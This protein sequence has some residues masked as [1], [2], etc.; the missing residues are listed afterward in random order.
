MTSSTFTGTPT[1]Q[2]SRRNAPASSNITTQTPAEFRADSAESLR[3]LISETAHDLRAPLTSV[4][5][6]IRLVRDGELGY[7][8]DSQRDCLSAAINQCNCA[9]QLVDEM[10]QSRQFDTG[11][12]NVCRRWMSIDDL[13]HSVEETLQPWTMPRNIH[14]LWDGP[15]GSGEMVY[16]DAIL[17]RRLL[18]NL[19]GNSIR[20]TPE[21]HS[22]LIR[23]KRN[24]R[25]TAYQW[26]IVDQG[27]GISVE[28]MQMIASGQAPA[29]STSGLGLLICR[30]LAAAHF[31]TL[32]LE[33]RVGTGTAASFDTVTGGPMAVVKAW[34]SWRE[35]LLGTTVTREPKGAIEPPQVMTPRR[36]RIDVPAS[37]RVELT[38]QSQTPLFP[39]SMVMTSVSIGAAT[40]LESADRF[41]KVLQRSLR[42][43]EL[44]YRVSDRSWVIAWDADAQSAVV[45]RNELENQSVEESAPR[46][47]WRQF[48]VVST[49]EPRTLANRMCDL[50]VRSA[51]GEAQSLPA[52]PLRD[53]PVIGPSMVAA[54]RL[55][56]Q[57]HRLRRDFEYEA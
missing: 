19:A 49:H 12:P 23:A 39:E 48:R 31:S 43:T 27:V 17:L 7:L 14:L 6:S 20:A 16:G 42:V 15:F 53:E 57:V 52:P 51:L 33:S 46:L 25:A 40:S 38:C 35:G 1:E 24:A 18:V 30:H 5:E 56:Q 10:V 11:F 9:G 32:R 41:E 36:M 45:R 50:L 29:S 8:T 26:S 22:I 55:E 54:A 13:R 47:Q 21:G 4:R 44:G 28:D 37:N 34:A 3:R 2:R